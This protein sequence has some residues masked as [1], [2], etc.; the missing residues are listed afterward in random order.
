MDDTN[1]SLVYGF[2][3]L[4]I[5]AQQLEIYLADKPADIDARC[6]LLGF[7]F[8]DSHKSA[9][10]LRKRTQH[11]IWMIQNYPQHDICG[12]PECRPKEQDFSLAKTEWLKQLDLRPT[13][14]RVLLYAAKFFAEH[15]FTLAE[16]LFVRGKE[17]DGDN[18]I[19][20]R[21]LA[22]LYSMNSDDDNHLNFKALQE[23]ET[24]LSLASHDDRTYTLQNLTRYALAA[25]DFKKANLYAEEIISDPMMQKNASALYTAR[26]VLAKLSL[27]KIDS[28][29]AKLHIDW[30]TQNLIDKPLNCLSREMRA[31]LTELLLLNEKACVLAYLQRCKSWTNDKLVDSAISAIAAGEKTKF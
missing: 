8:L 25:N 11:S 3:M 18:A 7:Y 6:K 16:E 22:H 28:G 14:L 19:W 10:S 23:Q 20:Y 2:K 4:P 21:Q 17:L 9:E 5:E 29:A 12:K 15:D 26:T 31:V 27:H 13:D 24:A 30:L 1:E